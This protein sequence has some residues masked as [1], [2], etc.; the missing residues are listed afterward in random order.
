[1]GNASITKQVTIYKLPG[2]N[3]SVIYALILHACS[4]GIDSLLCINFIKFFMKIMHSICNGKS[5]SLV[6][7]NLHEFGS[8]R[9]KINNLGIFDWQ[10]MDCVLDVDPVSD[11]GQVQG[12]EEAVPSPEGTPQ[13]TVIS[14]PLLQSH[15]S[16]RP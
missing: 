5:E 7:R 14:A 11:V 4:I 8:I 3:Q 6:H 12:H 1:M 15:V 13:H 2:S 16:L 9:F 10:Y